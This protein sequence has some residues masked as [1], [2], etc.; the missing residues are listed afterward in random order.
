MSRSADSLPSI[1][2][3]ELL[4]T[5]VSQINTF[6][7]C[8]RKWWYDKVGKLPRKTGVAQNLGTEIHAQIEHYLTTGEDVLGTIAAEGKEFLPAPSSDLLIETPLTNPEMTSHGVL[9]RGF[10]D[11]VVP[12]TV[13]EVIDWKTTSSIE[14]YA[15]HASALREDVQTTTYAEWIARKFGV[16][17]VKVSLVYFQTKGARCAEKVST[18]LDLTVIR[19]VWQKTEA[20]V[21]AQKIV[22][23]ETDPTNVEGN[24]EACTAYGGCDFA[25]VCPLS[26]SRR[27]SMSLIDRLNGNKTTPAPLPSEPPVAGV[28]AGDCVSGETYKYDTL[29][30]KC[31][32]TAGKWTLF[33][34]DNGTVLRLAKDVFVGAGPRSAADK[35]EA[36]SP[37]VST[38][39]APPAPAADLV[40]VLP[41]DAPPSLPPPPT[42]IAEEKEKPKRG[43]PPKVS[44]AATPVV[45][46]VEPLVLY[47]NCFPRRPAQDLS[48]Y[49]SDLC[50]KLA[51]SAGLSDVRLADGQN[52]LGFG[53]WRGALAAAAR[54]NP[55]KGSCVIVSGD[56]ADPVIE[57]LS[58][59]AVEVVRGR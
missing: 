42:S 51:L 8:Q 25:S 16:D 32:G 49:I 52:P 15:K 46:V 10:V 22:A 19:D 47:V 34:Y 14:R 26:P 7:L 6:D 38:T 23:R 28:L 13:P 58:A 35:E 12:G 2:D 11:C 39:T 59:I 41:P 57:A 53:K 50:A 27:F 36:P 29:A 24:T 18:V 48:A 54:E 3:G 1:V 56:L 44:T 20:K 40:S 43:R 37:V 21:A 33:T 5:S 30:V 17:Q 31:V 55:P 9:W 45:T 4:R